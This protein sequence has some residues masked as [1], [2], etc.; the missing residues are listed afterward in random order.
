MILGYTKKSVAASWIFLGY[1]LGNFVGPLL[2]KPKDAPVYAPGFTAVVITSLIAA[3]LAL[4]YRFLAMWENKKRDKSGVLE[5]Y[6]HAYDDDLTDTK[7]M[8]DPIILQRSCKTNRHWCRILNSDINFEIDHCALSQALDFRLL[9][10]LKRGRCQHHC[11]G[12]NR[13]NAG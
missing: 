12:V 13:W 2:F 6:E 5:D 3:A 4:C 11:P 10:Q 8:C 7:V 9:C 1:C